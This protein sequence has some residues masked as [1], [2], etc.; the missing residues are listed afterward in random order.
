MLSVKNSIKSVL[1]S[2]ISPSYKDAFPLKLPPIFIH[3]QNLPEKNNTSTFLVP[4][5]WS[6]IQPK[7]EQR[8]CLMNCRWICMYTHCGHDKKDRH[9]AITTKEA[10]RD[11]M[12]LQCING[13]QYQCQ[14]KGK[15]NLY[16]TYDIHVQCNNLIHYQSGDY[17]LAIGVQSVFMH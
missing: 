4:I 16:I 6:S 14:D 2:S 13:I 5:Y 1:T 9:R 11:N 8:A 17:K 3:G 15:Y 12:A 10:S 7:P